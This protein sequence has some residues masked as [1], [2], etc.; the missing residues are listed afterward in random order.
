MEDCMS[1]KANARRLGF[2][3]VELLVV[4]VIIGALAAMALT[5]G[6]KMMA[7]SK[8]T[9]SM[10][11]IRQ[12]GPL[13]MTYASEHSMSLPPVY[14]PVT[15]PDGTTVDSQ[16]NEVVLSLVYP[17]TDPEEFKTQTWWAD[18]KA[19]LRNPLFK[20]TAKPR[21]WEPL[22]P[23]YAINELI[24][25]N[26]EIAAG[27]PA[28]SQEQLLAVPVPLAAIDE[29]NRTP[30]IAPCDNYYYRYDE[31]EILGFNRGTLKDLMVDGKVPILFVDNHLETIVPKEYIERQLHFLP[32]GNLTNSN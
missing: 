20:E 32:R 26:V 10:Q 2:T 7:K 27:R 12:I 16:W 5:L 23:G 11:N 24:A 31:E 1:D 8:A 18:N 29:P 19:F 17:N 15:R 6:P 25:R 13:L 14:G 9:E 22:N 30:L 3:L 21:G 28:S 4:I